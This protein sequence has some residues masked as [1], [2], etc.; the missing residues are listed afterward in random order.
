MNFATSYK[1]SLESRRPVPDLV[2]A[3]E[4][5]SGVYSDGLITVL[6]ARLSAAISNAW[7]WLLGHD[8]VPLVT[9][10]LGD[11][12]FWSGSQ[13]AVFSIEAQSGKS[14]YVDREISYLF[15]EFLTKEGVQ[16]QVLGGHIFPLL[17]K[18]LGALSYGQCYIAVP[19]AKFGGSGAVDNYS[20]GEVDVYLSLNA[21]TAKQTFDAALSP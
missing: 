18:R 11:F 7:S 1:L 12:F 13:S 20:T 10:S 8:A 19:L 6:D 3:L 4:I 21:Q 9:T 16:D 2:K 5:A 17:A 14:T 15:D